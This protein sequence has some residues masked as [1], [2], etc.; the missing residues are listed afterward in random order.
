[1]KRPAL[2]RPR[3]LAPR[4]PAVLDAHVPGVRVEGP[5][6]LGAVGRLERVAVLVQWAPD[7]RLS[8]SVLELTRSLAGHDYQVVLVSASEDS[9]ELEWPEERPANVTVLR[10]PNIGYDFGSWAAALDWRPQI[11]EAGQVLLMNDSLAGPFAPIDDLLGRFDESAAD[12]WGLTDSTQL[13]QFHLQSYCLGFK[14]R[15]LLEAPLVRFWRDLRVEQSRDDVIRRY[16]IGLGRLLR[17][18]RFISEAAFRYGDVVGDG[19]NPTIHGWSRLLD[20][21]FPF[22]KRELLRRPEV[23]KDGAMVRAELQRRYGVDVDDWL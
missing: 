22:V 1:M 15:S 4:R 6:Q 8:R 18:E 23:A 9:R 2:P 5:D 17:R 21:G 7:N 3:P 19:M 14:G 11:A 13:G 16:E 20:L 12:V 10:R